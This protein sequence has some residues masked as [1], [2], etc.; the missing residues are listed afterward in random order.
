[1]ATV[2]AISLRE[3]AR[4]GFPPSA[5]LPSPGWSTPETRRSSVLF[6]EPFGPRRPRT[7]PGAAASEMP[8]STQPAPP[9]A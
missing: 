6:P 9:S 4:I 5:T 2:R 1:M 3:S 7:S 8:S